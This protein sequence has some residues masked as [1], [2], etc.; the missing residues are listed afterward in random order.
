[1][2]NKR[3]L[4]FTCKSLLAAVPRLLQAANSWCHLPCLLALTDLQLAAFALP[5]PVLLL[6][7]LP[8]S[9]LP[10]CIHPA[11]VYAAQ[12]QDLAAGDSP[13]TMPVLAEV[14]RQCSL[15]VAEQPPGGRHHLE[16]MH[17]ARPLAPGSDP[18]CGEA[19]GSRSASA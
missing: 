17:V 4:W 2:L 11:A 16:Q 18:A 9:A 3:T 13:M 1:M 19:P 5:A 7:V 12:L 8:Y 6:P 14:C 15:A 10:G